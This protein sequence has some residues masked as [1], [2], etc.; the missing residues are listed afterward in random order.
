M[1]P[2]PEYVNE[3]LDHLLCRQVQGQASMI[4]V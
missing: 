4:F 1:A 2:A 3:F